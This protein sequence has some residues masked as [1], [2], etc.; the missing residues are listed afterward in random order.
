MIKGSICNYIL[1]SKFNIFS[2]TF[3]RISRNTSTIFRLSRCLY[4]M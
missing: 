1:R 4:F 3:F 2:S